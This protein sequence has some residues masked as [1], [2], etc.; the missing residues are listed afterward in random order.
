ME[1]SGRT[2][3]P[4]LPAQPGPTGTLK[5]LNFGYGPVY[6]Y[7]RKETKVI[8]KGLRPNLPPLGLDD[9][10]LEDNALVSLP[11]EPG[12]KVY[13]F[14]DGMADLTDPSGKRYG[15]T[16]VREFLSKAY[17]YSCAEFIEK[18]EAE[19][20]AWQGSAPQADDITVLT[21]QA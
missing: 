12:T 18:T 13:T 19:I 16:A 8:G 10:T 9:L 6:Y 3:E 1:S 17:R 11:F 4:P 21:V 20:A 5:I 15:E 2:H 14:S 7:A